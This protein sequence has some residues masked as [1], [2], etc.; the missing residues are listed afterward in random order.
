MARRA[1][2]IERDLS[3]LERESAPHREALSRLEASLDA[4]AA[5]AHRLSKRF[6]AEHTTFTEH[7]SDEDWRLA[8]DAPNAPQ[9]VRRDEDDDYAGGDAP[10]VDR[11]EY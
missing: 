6:A 9:K 8:A 2:A 4:A 1:E 3:R 7:R 11:S 5:A 10:S